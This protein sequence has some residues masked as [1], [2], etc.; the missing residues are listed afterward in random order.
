VPVIEC[1]Q[2]GGAIGVDQK[3]QGDGYQQQQDDDDADPA[4][5][6]FIGVF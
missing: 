1:R 4:A 3:G 6:R 2:R 5:M